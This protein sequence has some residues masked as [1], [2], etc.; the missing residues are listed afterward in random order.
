MPKR[1]VHVHPFLPAGLP[2]S[3][4]EPTDFNFELFLFDTLRSPHGLLP[5]DEAS[6]WNLGTWITVKNTVHASQQA[7]KSG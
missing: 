3:T 7:E 2:T 1:A 5:E 4:R 6:L